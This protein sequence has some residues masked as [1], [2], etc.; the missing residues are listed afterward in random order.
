[1]APAAPGRSRRRSAGDR[2]AQL[3]AI[4]LELLPTTPVQELTIDE[5]AR[6]AGISR[7]LLFHYFA[8][9]RDYYTAV[10]RAAADVLLEHLAPRTG[11]P[12]RGQAAGMLER[13]VSWVE[14]Y[15]EA[16]LSFVRGAAA[17]DPWVAEVYEETRE[18]L[19]DVTLAALDVPDDE[20][21]RQLVR[22]WFAFTEDLVGQWVRQPTLARADL[23]DLL[24]DLLD[25]LL[26]PRPAGPQP[27]P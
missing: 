21:R 5:V 19:V 8:S 6:R 14:T 13:Y 3:V 24:R 23:V 9:K 1:M 17:G 15:R 12:G 16:H 26:A 25:G 11:P 20:H 27:G 18:Q 4:G 2:R 22:A 7:S 10:T